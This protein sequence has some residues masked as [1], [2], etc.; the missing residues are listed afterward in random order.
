[1]EAVK[2]VYLTGFMGTGKSTVGPALARLLKRPWADLD[3]LIVRAAKKSV[4]EIFATEGEPAF[5]RR[6]QEALAM[7]A[8]KGGA[9]ISLGGGTL[10]APANGEIVAGSGTLVLLTCARRELARR[11]APE[12][13]VR[14]KLAGGSLDA[15]LRELMAER[16]DAYG[17]PDFS[18][19]TTRLT[20]AAAAAAIARR[21]S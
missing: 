19:S 6:E 18:I 17:R 16:G 11:L 4:A 10:L 2:N 12:R 21:L 14:P 3:A 8:L 7:A 20:P 5:R 15:R 1:V 9:V 13:A